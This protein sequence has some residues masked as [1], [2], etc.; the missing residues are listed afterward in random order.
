MKRQ[1]TE[2]QKIFARYSLN[3]GLI[4]YIYKE[5]KKLNTKRTNNPI[6]KWANALNRQFS[7]EVQMAKEYMNKCSTS[8]TIKEMQVRRTLKL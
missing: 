6:N 3:K 4:S 8:L 2:W 1:C 5:L 7:K